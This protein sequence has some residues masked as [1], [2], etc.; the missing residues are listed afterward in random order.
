MELNKKELE[1]FNENG[2]LLI[3]GFLDKRSCEIIKEIAK[4]HLK[5]KIEPIETEYEYIGIDKEEYKKSVRRLRQVYDRD[6]VF[7]NWMTNKKIYPILEQILKEEPILITAHHNSI[8]TKLAK[9]STH[10]CWHRDSRYWHYDN[11]NLVSIWLA[12]GKE[13]SQNG[14]L[15]FIPKSHKMKL[16]EESFDEKSFFREDWEINKK[17]VETKVSYNLEA[18]DIVLFHSELLHR[19]NA[20]KS[21]QDKISFVY[22]VKGKSVNAIKGTRSSKFKEIELKNS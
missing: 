13:N 21:N 10:T 2:F 11:T 4:I 20:N 5:Y 6:I 19:A 17:L 12:L 1:E 16:S 22:T 3:R 18:G 8:M 7:K 15:E 9:T 14:V